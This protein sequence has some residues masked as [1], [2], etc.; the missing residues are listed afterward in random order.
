MQ[1]TLRTLL[2]WLDGRLPADEQQALGEKVSA[3][4]FASLLAER[5]RLAMGRSAI[6]AP[7]LDARGLGGDANSVA[8]FLDNSLPIDQRPAFERICVESDMHL[9]EVAACHAIFAEIARNTAAEHGLEE[10]RR[11]SLKTLLRDRLAREPFGHAGAPATHGTADEH[12]ES[13]ETARALREA[14][15]PAAAHGSE[16]PSGNQGRHRPEPDAVA[17]S[18]RPADPPPLLVESVGGSGPAVRGKRSSRAAWWSALIAL[19]LLVTLVGV[20]AWSMFRSAGRRGAAPQQVAAAGDA[21]AEPAPPVAPVEAVAAAVAPAPAAAEAP[22]REDADR[23]LRE[24]A[25]GT[26]SAPPGAPVM[27]STPADAS[28]SA[29]APADA[30]AAM[31]PRTEPAQPGP[32]APAPRP[33]VPAAPAATDAEIGGGTL[34]RLIREKD[35]EEWQVADAGVDLR[36]GDELL[37]PPWCEAS[38][39]LR[40]VAVRLLSE[41]NAVFSVDRDGTPRLD[42]LSGRAVIGGGGSASR[43]GVT[44]GGLTGVVAAGPSTRIAIEAGDSSRAPG[45]VGGFVTAGHRPFTWQ[46]TT[47]DGS[48]APGTQPLEIAAGTAVVW[49]DGRPA[50]ATGVPPL[51]W[52][53]AAGLPDRIQKSASESLASKISTGRPL[54]LSLRELTVDRRIENRMIAAATLALI[55]KSDEL[56]EML[57]AESSSRNK[58]EDQ[59]WLT[60]ERMAVPAALARGGEASAGLHQAFID[61]GPRDKGELLWAMARGFSDAEITGGADRV[62]VESLDD[63]SLIVR[64]YAFKTLCDIVHPSAADKMRYRPDGLPDLRRAGVVWWKEQL[65][66]GLLHR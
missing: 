31:P 64:R 1:L 48:V 24:P 32:E 16:P 15:H 35:A 21:A 5:I 30:A 62:L 27:P 19:S 36:G 37:V 3:S 53:D 63:P 7:A 14:L 18:A 39:T 23:P 66:R 22:A 55:G 44:T 34:L 4:Q 56:V 61:R 65:S 8:E 51:A 59:Q 28:R 33:V 41:A 13:R 57:A 38:L 43:I 58:L 52:I 2:A 42:V 20:L 10:P 50:L 54:L 40:G 29:V 11:Q 45:D 26:A 60:L 25:E 6:G 9:A 49:R 12:H 46:P 47:A 17:A